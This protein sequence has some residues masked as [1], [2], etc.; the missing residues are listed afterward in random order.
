MADEKEKDYSSK[1]IA[2]SEPYALGAGWYVQ[3]GIIEDAQGGRKVRVARGRAN[4]QGGIIQSQ[5]INLK[6]KEWPWLREQ[7]DRYVTQLAQGGEDKTAEG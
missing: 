4:P 5:K 2:T 3:V 6:A 7:I 1:W